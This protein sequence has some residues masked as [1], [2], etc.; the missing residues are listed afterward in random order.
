MLECCLRSSSTSDGALRWNGYHAVAMWHLGEFSSSPATEVK[1]GNLSGFDSDRRHSVR[2]SI[3]EGSLIF[4][5]REYP[6]PVWHA[7]V[8]LR[9]AASDPTV[10][11]DTSK[12]TLP[13]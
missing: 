2:E 11:R 12:F 5:G 10:R 9:D 6:A 4:Q 1:T 7:P 8:K 13:P 3:S